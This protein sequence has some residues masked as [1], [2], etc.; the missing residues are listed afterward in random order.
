MKNPLIL[1]ESFERINAL[2]DIYDKIGFCG[3]EYRKYIIN[4]DKA[5]SLNPKDVIENVTKMMN[6]GDNL[7][8]IRE[9]MTENAN[10]IF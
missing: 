2:S 10:R 8:E 5:F 3:E 6:D 1:N 9:Y 4:F 7:E